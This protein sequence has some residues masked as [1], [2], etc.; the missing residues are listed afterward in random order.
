[1]LVE[2]GIIIVAEYSSLNAQNEFHSQVKQLLDLLRS[3]ESVDKYLRRTVLLNQFRTN[4][5]VGGRS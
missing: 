5:K 2:P 3:N 1:M 4:A